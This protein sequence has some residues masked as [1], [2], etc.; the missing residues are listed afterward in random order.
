MNSRREFLKGTALA[1]AT[2]MA[3]G[4]LGPGAA[5]CSCLG[6]PMQGFAAKPLKQ[7]RVGLIGLGSRGIG[8]SHRLPMIPG[9]VVTAF[10]ELR[11]E[12]VQMA[13]KWYAQQGLPQ[14]KVFLGPEAYKAMCDWDGIDVVYSVTPWDLHAPIAAY[15]MEHGK[16][17]FNEVPGAE[18]IDE[19]W[20]LI[21]TAEKTKQHCMMLEN[22]CYGE[23]EM[24][25]LNLIRQG[26][27]G[28]LVHGEA[29]YIHDQRKLHYGTKTMWAPAIKD[30]SLKNPDAPTW[31]IDKFY[32]EHHGNYYP[33]HGLGPVCKYMNINHGD[34]FDYLVSLESRQASMEHY[35]KTCYPPNSWQAQRKIKKGDMNLSLIRTA[36]GRSI[37]LE[38][39][40]MSPRP[41]D[42]LNLITGTKGIARGYPDLY[43]AWEE[44]TGDQ[45]SHD[46]LS[47]EKTEEIRQKYKHPLWKAVGEIA[48]KV[49]GHGGMDFIMD[50]RWSY[51]LQN[52]LPLDTD[53]YDLASWSALVEI[54]ERSVEGGSSRQEIPDFTRGGWKT[55]KPFGIVDVDVSK[56]NLNKAKKDNEQQTV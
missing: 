48:K 37:L 2:A 36:L 21:E 20:W 14:P 25:A 27:L 9:T 17:V 5:K 8:A 24:L 1:G 13:Q 56:L 12:R 26:K 52:G 28:E 47:R 18:T 34:K 10:C 55:A 19:C 4:C 38:H 15:A 23:Y 43:L 31:C 32:A 3:A 41:Y 53:V 39:D 11:P 46:Y 22:C 45:K 40:I 29:G 42:R 50:L 51:C 35:G 49:G 6:A 7:V 44:Q 30:M 33:T 54:T 16:H